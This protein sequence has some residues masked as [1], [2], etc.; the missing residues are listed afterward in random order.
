MKKSMFLTAIA[1][2][3]ILSGC[4]SQY[5]FFEPSNKS[6]IPESTLFTDELSSLSAQQ[7]AAYPLLKYSSYLP[8]A[9]F[10]KK[11]QLADFHL[12]RAHGQNGRAKIFYTDSPTATGV[13]AMGIFF[14]STDDY[15][16]TFNPIIQDWHQYNI[17]L[18]AIF[19]NQNSQDIDIKITDKA[20]KMFR[21]KYRLQRKWNKLTIDLVSAGRYIDLTRIANVKFHFYQIGQTQLYIDDIIL[22]NHLHILSGDIDGKPGTMFVAKAGKRLRIG[23]NKRFELVFADGNI[24]G[25]FDL[26]TDKY[27]Q[28]NLTAINGLGPRIYQITDNGKFLPLPPDKTLLSVHTSIV[29]ISQR[30]VKIIADIFFGSSISG[31]KSDQTIIY[32]IRANGMIKIQICTISSSERLGVAF[33]LDAQQGFDSIIGKIR[34]PLGSSDSSIEYCLFRRMGKQQGAD[35][36]IA[37]KP[38]IKETGSVKC[39]LIK[40]AHR[41]VGVFISKAETGGCCM[42]GMINSGLST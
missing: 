2:I 33:E 5:R 18:C 10:E 30:R 34:N 41:L 28:N 13:G 22:A 42:N 7:F 24:V 31:R 12:S 8:L 19:C 16:L 14:A 21:R 23:V 32:D 29:H 9:D 15:T 17:L 37:F 27:R 36:L 3:L 35:M 39:K 11:W 1:Y 25:W 20:G 4:S 40:N 38:F 26:T 6:A